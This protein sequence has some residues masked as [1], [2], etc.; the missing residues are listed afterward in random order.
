MDIVNSLL[1]GFDV[2]L[3]PFNLAMAF[4]GSFLGTLIG[5]LPGIGP[6]NGVAILIPI[7]FSLGL[8]PTASLILLSSVYYGCMFGG[9]I[10]SIL[11]NIPG[12][13]PA[14]MTCLDGYPMARKGRAADALAIS[15]VSSFIGGTLATIGLTLFAP[16]LAKVAIYFGPAEYFA[17]YVLAMATI[18]G[19]TGANPVKTLTAAL[20]GLVLSTVGIDPSTGVPR[21]TF[22]VYKLY[23]G[24][25]FVVAL[26]GLFA[27][28]EFLVYLETAHAPT[29]AMP[30]G[31]ITSPLRELMSMAASLRGS[32]LGFIAGVLPG[33]GASL[34]SFLAYALEKR[35]SDR[36][37][38][39]GKGDPRGIA[40]PEAGN[41]AAAGGALVP[42]LT[43]G[44]PGS[45]TTAVLLGM[46]ISLNI[47]P[48]PLLF[49]KQPEVVWGLIASLYIGNVM[50]L[51]LNIPLVGVFARI[52]TTPSWIM[53]PMVV[54]VSFVGVYSINHS[55]FDLV[56]MTG[57]GVIGY[58][59]RKMDFS[60]VPVVLGL[61]LGTP[62]EQ[63]LRRAL[64]A[65]DG[66][67]SILVAS[68]LSVILYL[69][70]AT[71]LGLAVFFEVRRLA[72]QRR[73]RRL[74][75]HTASATPD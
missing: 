5:A 39:F 40:A 58:V 45:G 44:V 69:V 30:I 8:G 27:I 13:E 3:T 54:V 11:L 47:T 20:I 21:Y 70:T 72:R 60:L 75:A 19:V 16:F 31:R 68:P 57:F 37:G 18:G 59:L 46:L 38:T 6:V 29:R 56:L 61:L 2:A 52:L 22:D 17:L 74:A 28:S 10:S 41:N 64:S 62:M 49:E 34:G 14:L 33:A 24:I 53:M 35:Y 50:L 55:A 67:W 15:A 26:V 66:E 7:A 48:G 71:M 32:V 25:D 73:E 23:D 12:D 51:V 65:S 9:R 43:L 4:I 36:N 63:N 1:Y 42:M